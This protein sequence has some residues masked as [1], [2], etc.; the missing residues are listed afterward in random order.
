[1]LDIAGYIHQK[2]GWKNAKKITKTFAWLEFLSDSLME[3]HGEMTI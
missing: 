3:E 2:N 1:M